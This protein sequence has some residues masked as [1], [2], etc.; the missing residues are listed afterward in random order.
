MTEEEGQ[1]V[2][3]REYQSAH[4]DLRREINL[5]VR[6]A[7]KVELREYVEALLTE[8]QR[9]TEMAERERAQAADVLLGERRRVAEAAERE[10]DKAAVALSTQVAQQI[11]QTDSALRDHIAQQIGQLQIMLEALRREI[12]IRGGEQQKA[13]E[14]SETS[15][16]K[17]FDAVNEFRSQLSDLVQRHQAALSQLTGTLMPR[18]VAEAQ[19][20][21]V[22]KLSE[23][24]RDRS[25]PRET[26]DTTVSEWTTWRQRIDDHISRTGGMTAGRGEH[27]KQTQI[28]TATLISVAVAIVTA[29]GVIIALANFATSH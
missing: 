13:I 29:L 19:I 6:N 5:A 28:T 15:Y 23:A 10:R 27:R 17:R 18:E 26:F 2:S 21:E 20:A 14:K 24:N 16:D 8:G 9:A 12:E 3:H 11:S 1:F 7:S 22:R 4:E 25:L